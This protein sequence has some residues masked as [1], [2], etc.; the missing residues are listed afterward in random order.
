[1]EASEGIRVSLRGYLL[2]WILIFDHFQNASFKVKSAYV[3]EL[4][5]GRYLVPLLCLVFDSLPRDRHFDPSKFE[6]ASYTPGVSETPASDAQW[7]FIHIYYLSLRYAPSLV[8]SWWLECKN[9]ATVQTVE[10]FTK[11]HMSP[12]LVEMEL[13]AVASWAQ[14]RSADDDEAMTVK[15]SKM[16]REVTAS[17]PV[18][19]QA[20]D[21]LVRLPSTFPLKPVEVEGLRRVGLNE[22]QFKRMQLASQAAVN[23]WS[24]SIID[25]LTLFSKNVKLHFQG[26]TECAI[27]YS[28]LAV[29]PDRSLPNKACSTCKNKFHS[30]CLLKWFKSSNSSSC[31]LCR[32]SFSFYY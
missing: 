11:N 32:T 17:Y 8:K 6:P 30:G 22:Q 29:T 5:E 26:I 21:L 1:M 13:S 2:S 12:L 18:D 7:L 9:R 25:A 3:E 15:V 19:D 27:C 31:P 24:G 4:K 28:I 16:A 23:F 14:S 10:A 20:M